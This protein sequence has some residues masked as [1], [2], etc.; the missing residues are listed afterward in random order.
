M[1]T[2]AQTELHQEIDSLK[3]EILQTKQEL[4]SNQ[5]AGEAAQLDFL[6]KHLL[7]LNSQLVFMREQQTILMQSTQQ[8]SPCH[9]LSETEPPLKKRQLD[10]PPEVQAAAD[11]L[12]QVVGSLQSQ[13]FAWLKVS[14]PEKYSFQRLKQ[15]ANEQQGSCFDQAGEV[16]R[17]K[18]LVEHY[19]GEP[20][21]KLSQAVRRAADEVSAAWLPPV[22]PYIYPCL[23]N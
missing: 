23:N 20:H 14:S 5:H 11:P 19:V 4:A 6:Q 9:H 15:F 1:A 8:T 3:A 18:K 22:S 7:Q 2:Q 12:D 10:Q 21:P 13:G 17:D 16:L